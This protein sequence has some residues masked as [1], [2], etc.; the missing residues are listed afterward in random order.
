MKKTSKGFSL[1]L[2]LLVLVLFSS[3]NAYKQLPYLKSPEQ[4]DDKALISELGIHEPRI[5]PNDI[6]SITVNSTIAGA[7]TD[8]NLP[9]IPTNAL[10]TV[11]TSAMTGVTSSGSIQN[12]FVDKKGT[13]TFPV[14][15]EIKIGGMTTKEAQE[16]IADLIHPRYI[17]EKPIVNVR[18][19]NFKV[20][21]LGE[22]ARPGV[23]ESEN[24][25]M[26]ILDALA[27][28]GD[29]TIYGKRENVTL[30]RTNDNGDIIS[31]KIDMR[32]KDVLQNKEIFYLQQNDKLLVEANKARGNSSRFGSF[33]SISLSALSIVI[34]VV[35]I[36]T[37]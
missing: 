16:Y 29:M 4:Q 31:Y 32:N 34:S 1:N 35:A 19:L 14:L 18:F 27:S 5:M 8:F 22:V 20:S 10:E 33:E 2:I 13:V 37:R 28:A 24:G 12:Y 17:T 3:C 36:I 26:S 6:V 7:A 15:G 23:Y 30:I 25:Q 21:V 11:Q 9:I